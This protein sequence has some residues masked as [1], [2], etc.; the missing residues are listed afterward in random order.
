MLRIG[1][2]TSMWNPWH[3]CHKFS[4]GCQHCYVYRTDGKYGKDSSVVTKTEKF[5]LP[6]QLKKNKT[7]KI[8]S[9]NLVYTCFTSDFLVEDADVWRPEAWEMMRLRQD[10]HFLFITKRIDRLKDCLPPDWGEGYDNVTICC[11]MENQDRIDYRLPIYKAAPIKHKIII[12]EP[13]LSRIDFR[14][15]LGEWVEQ[16]VAG[17]ESG[18]EAR[19]C[20]YD[21]VLEIRRQCIDANVGFWFKQTGSFL[22]KDG[23]EFKVA[24]QFQHSQARKA[25]INY[26]PDRTSLIE[27]S[28]GNVIL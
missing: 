7:Y 12:C 6:V 27:E 11:T 13:L 15:E 10:L 16:V 24:R 8:P 28:T 1:V 19:V 18:R 9:G 25:E 23:K 4:T 20:D 22:L 14:G 3:G 21:W 26:E 5:N 2:K 17:G